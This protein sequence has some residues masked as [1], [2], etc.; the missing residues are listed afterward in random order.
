MT[1]ILISV[2]IWQSCKQERDC[3]VHFLRLLALCWP[4]MQSARDNHVLPCNF[5]KYSPIFNFFI[6]RPINKPFLIWIT[7]QTHLKY[8][9]TLPRNL[10][11]RACFFA[12]INVS[13]GNVATYARCGGI[14]NIHLTANLQRNLPVKNF[15][16]RLRFD[17][18]MVMS[19]WPRFWPKTS[20][21]L[22]LNNYVKKLTDFDNF[23]YVKF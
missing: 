16:D 21:F 9:A 4:G 2:N 13:Q 6:H 12:D 23:W 5:A 18:I 11:L 20:T 3:L 8:V 1:I 17:R 10:S 15:L 14:F 7:N 19:M 22:F